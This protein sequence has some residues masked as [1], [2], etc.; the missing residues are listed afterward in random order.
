MSH[1]KAIAEQRTDGLKASLYP[2]DNQ[3]VISLET[4]GVRL[5]TIKLPRSIPTFATINNA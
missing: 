2:L 5:G 4:E 1:K 3:A